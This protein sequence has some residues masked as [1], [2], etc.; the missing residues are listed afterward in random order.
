MNWAKGRS[1]RG[2]GTSFKGALTYVLHDKAA[3]SAERVGF[4]ELVNLATDE[5]EKAWTEMMA[6]CDA[7]EDLKRRA[8][9]KATGRKMTK[10][11]YAFTLNW[12]EED[13]PNPEH[14]RETALTALRALGLEDRQAVIVEHTDRPHRHVHIIVN[15]IDPVTGKSACLSNDEH[16]LDRWADDYE[17]AQG[18][19]RSP[20]R[21]AKFHALDHGLKPP[22]RPV[23][24]SSREEWEATRKVRGERARERAA[25]IR[26]AYAERVR[27][28]KADQQV[29]FTLRRTEAARLWNRY[30]A[31]RKGVYD[32][33]Q[34][35]INA[36]WKRRR[37]GPPHPA[38]EQ[39][40]HD[41][42]ESAAWRQLGRKQ[43]KHRRKFDARE[44]SILGVIANIVRL[45]H[46]RIGSPGLISLFKLAAS[47]IERYQQFYKLLDREKQDLRRRQ[48]QT[49]SMRADTLRAARRHELSE[50]A[51]S[52]EREDA[53]LKSRHEAERAGDKAA[54]RQLAA[55]RQQVWSD[56][57]RDYARAEPEVQQDRG[58]PGRT[59]G[60]EPAPPRGKEAAID[61]A[62]G[63]GWRA[64][65][66]AAER[67]ADGSYRARERNQDRG[68]RQRQRDRY[69]PS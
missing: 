31:D 32:R 62:N 52:F 7:A 68:G 49:R 27:K 58:G 47:K 14:M 16:K 30:K 65:R 50:L 69:D 48:A 64:R 63:K 22:K 53:M 67:K 3:A 8:G 60:K 15:L 29:A 1:T 46:A 28:M 21:R 10:P 17:Q 11:V 41:M 59:G 13:R 44:R 51:K 26:A 40:W 42:Q 35:F 24:A 23:Q 54:W 19:I 55:E 18:I 45:H 66:S 56:Y 9:I 25:A 34:P 43:F 5:P 39:A 38:T 2:R 12:H 37:T 4:I 6:L 36:I 57:H 33:Y 61:Q 20:D